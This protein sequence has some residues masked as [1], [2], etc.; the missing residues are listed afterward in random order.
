MKN[1]QSPK[2]S[3]AI[4]IFRF[5]TVLMRGNGN[6]G[7]KSPG[8]VKLENSIEH[9]AANPKKHANT[10]SLW[11]LLERTKE[12]RPGAETEPSTSCP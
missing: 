7:G 3:K 9:S 5:E 4:R 11:K 2:F 12:E 10:A 8:A 6:I 1:E